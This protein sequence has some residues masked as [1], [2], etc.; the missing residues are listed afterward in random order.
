[1]LACL[2]APQVVTSF[3]ALALPRTNQPAYDSCPPSR[4]ASSLAVVDL[5]EHGS[6]G[7]AFEVGIRTTG[8]NQ[9]I[10]PHSP[11]SLSSFDTSDY[12]LTESDD[13]F[14]AALCEAQAA[15]FAMGT[16]F[17]AGSNLSEDFP[18]PSS[19]SAMFPRLPD[20][21][22]GGAIQSPAG[23]VS[24]DST[25]DGL[26]V[27]EWDRIVGEMLSSPA[28]WSDSSFSSQASP[29]MP[30]LPSPE[31]AP[32]EHAFPHVNLSSADSPRCTATSIAAGTLDFLNESE[33]ATLPNLIDPLD[34]VFGERATAL[35]QEASDTPPEVTTEDIAWIN[36]IVNPEGNLDPFLAAILDMEMDLSES[37]SSGSPAGSIDSCFPEFDQTW[38]PISPALT[39]PIISESAFT[40]NPVAQ[41]PAECHSA[42]VSDVDAYMPTSELRSLSSAPT[43]ESRTLE[44]AQAKHDA[45]SLQLQAATST[46]DASDMITDSARP[47]LVEDESVDKIYANIL[48][49]QPESDGTFACAVTTC[50]RRFARRYNLKT[51]FAAAHCD[52][53]EFRCTEAQCKRAPFARKYDLIRH[54]EKHGRYQC[55]NC[56]RADFRTTLEVEEHRAKIH[57]RGRF[58]TPRIAGKRCAPT[59]AR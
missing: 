40:N 6:V 59:S 45:A 20:S 34:F 38:M 27:D 8:F 17:A 10:W 44:R 51:H 15:G 48:Q 42:D 50:G 37:D 5:A 13:A 24:I 16:A 39:A 19:P 53:R 4:A 55:V 31:H 21:M 49:T 29:A 52:I 14:A 1:M 43:T 9:D 58:R 22:D 32:A 2:P 25:V 3:P 11:L 7:A 47:Q 56:D 33:Q 36:A 54:L 57:R 12:A 26:A 23:N 35:I 46:I 18:N 28:T 30:F 41:L